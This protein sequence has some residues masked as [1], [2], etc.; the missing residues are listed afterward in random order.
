MFYNQIYDIMLLRLDDRRR[1]Y[2]S[3]D[4]RPSR[5]SQSY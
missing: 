5:K 4:Y 3:I 2:E 1:Q